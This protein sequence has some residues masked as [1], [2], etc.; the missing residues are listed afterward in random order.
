MS[1]AILTPP[2]QEP[3]SLADA[4]L[5][6]RIA[7]SDD[8]AVISRLIVAARQHVETFT[9]R[10]LVTQ[11]LRLTTGSLPRSQRLILPRPP[12]Q[13]VLTVGLRDAA[14]TLAPFAATDFAADLAA[15]AITLSRRPVGLGAAGVQLQIDYRAGFGEPAAVPE[16]IRQA[17][18]LLVAGWTEARGALPG[19]GAPQGPPPA[20]ASLLAPWRVL[21]L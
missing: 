17:I 21:D 9:R 13:A 8:D 11:T 18:L 15:G 2:A 6:A 4:K 19:E 3:I 1:L 10:A 14:G 12:V 5:F 16:A 7:T 20:V